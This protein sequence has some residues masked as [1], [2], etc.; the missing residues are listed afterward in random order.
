MPPMTTNLAKRGHATECMVR[1]YT[2]RARGGV[3]LIVVE[4]AIVETPRGNHTQECLFIDDDKYINGLKEI[5]SNIQA[6][7]SKAFMNI[8]HGGRRA[9]RVEDG[10]LSVTRG[11]IPV[12]PSSLAH[13]VPG[14]VVPEE[15]SRDS[16][17]NIQDK[18]V[19]AAVRVR[20]AG[21][22]GISIHA[23]HMYLI[24]EFLSP[25]SNR[26]EDEYGGDINGRLLFLL[27]IIHAIKEKVGRDYPIM[28]RI[29][30]RE[31]IKDGITIDDVKYISRVLEEKGVNCISLSCGAGIALP[32]PDFPTPVAPMR[33]PH[34]LEVNLAHAVKQVVHCPV[35]TA[36]RIVVP[37]EAEL[38]LKDGKADLVGIG[39]GLI[40]D[41][42]WP[43]KALKNKTSEIRY[44]IGC[45]HCLRTVLQER[46]EIRCSINAVV[47]RE[48]ESDFAPAKKPKRVLVAGGG[49][50]G[51]EAA[52]VAALRGHKVTVYEKEMPGGQINL[53]CAPPGKE[54]FRLFKEY[55]LTQLKNFGVDIIHEE[56]TPEVIKEEKPDTVVIATGAKPI[57][58]DLPGVHGANV[59]TAFQALK[60]RTP[61]KKRVV[62][63]G[64]GDI[65]CE[66]AEYYASNNNDV[67]IIEATDQVAR[68]ME[69]TIRLL[70]LFSL[71]KLGVAI[72]TNAK[73]KEITEKGIK[74]II[75]ETEEI[76]KADIIV[77]A[78]GME[79]EI[80]L[81]Q[82]IQGFCREVYI[83]GDCLKPR[84]MPDATA[85]AFFEVGI[86]I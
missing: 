37:D 80:S 21:F 20:E 54:D 27:E 25:A 39:R 77:L 16:I 47:G 19:Q 57:I 48:K 35:M 59:V 52:R 50:A 64:G 14:F 28:V 79:P 9:G 23:A 68:N 15:L 33:L 13:P 63:L 75:N 29:N 82:N 66:V 56:L 40:A 4:D 2:E 71:E 34:A 32:I 45:M 38:I 70:L 60:N 18:F 31:G 51:L 12:A 17:K 65:G 41:P 6:A 1:Y 44:C 7:G 43:I 67:T 30:G 49:I 83:A 74:V 10:Y 3:G 8:N 46:R 5:A 85:E 73:A 36:N 55:E 84:R 72:L 58:P 86:R 81:S 24:S 53:S 22:D 78:V 62:V 11:R 69:R 42:E 61:S 76:L 26:R